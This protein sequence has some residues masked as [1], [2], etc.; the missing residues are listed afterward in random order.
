MQH[1]IQVAGQKI[2]RYEVVASVEEAVGLLA[3][4]GERAKLIAGGTDLIVELDRAERPGVDV[5]VDVSGLGGLTK[6]NYRQGAKARRVDKRQRIGCP[7]RTDRGQERCGL[8]R[9]L[10][11]IRWWGLRC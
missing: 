11:I 9:G 3:E 7:F 1:P 10:R 6:L 4:F 8:G 5:L 2:A